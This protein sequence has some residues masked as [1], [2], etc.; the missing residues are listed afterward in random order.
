MIWRYTTVLLFLV[1]TSCHLLG[2]NFVKPQVKI[3]PHWSQTDNFHVDAHEQLSDLLWWKEFKSPELDQLITTALHRNNDLQ[4]AIANVNKA[5]GELLRVKFEWL[6]ELNL[7]GGFTQ[8]PY[9]GNPGAFYIFFPKYVINL[10]KQYRKQKSA[11]ALV[12]AH[13]YAKDTVKL[14]IIAQVTTSYFTLLA[15]QQALGIHQQLLDEMS[16]DL[17]LNQKLYQHHLIAA[18]RLQGLERDIQLVKSRIQI[19]QHHIIVNKNA[20]HFLLNQNPGELQVLY[21][22]ETIDTDHS[23]PGNTPVNVLRNRPDVR[24]QEALLRAANEDIGV[25]TSTLLPSISI[26]SYLG[27]GSTVPASSILLAEGYLNQPLIDLPVFGDIKITRAQYQAMCKKYVNTIRNALRDVEND[28]SAYTTFRKQLD[29]N[30]T[31]YSHEKQQCH[32]VEVRYQYGIDNEI[33]KIHCKIKLAKFKLRLTQN[34]L[35]KIL[36]IVHLYQ[37]LG[38]GY[39]AP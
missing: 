19:T 24:E 33:D 2:P 5:R 12:K 35:E 13:C 7:L 25:A 6:P 31:A 37:D 39:H 15:E 32:L 4:V 29:Q 28:L 38:A 17:L 21:D 9:F 16:A 30:R 26:N 27:Q 34:K 23:A 10:F 20:L 8:M 11:E 3:S 14:T 18:D 22:F 36:S 1:M